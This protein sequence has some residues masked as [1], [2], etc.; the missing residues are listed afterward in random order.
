MPR[1]LSI[2]AAA[3]A[4]ALTG[5]CASDSPDSPDDQAAPAPTAEATQETTGGTTAPLL[6]PAGAEVGTV[7]LAFGSD[8]AT[9]VVQVSDLA[10]GYHGFHVHESGACEPDSPS[11]SDP[12]KVGDFLSAGGHLA[13]GDQ[14]HGEHDGDLPSLLVAAD[15]TASL[16]VTSDRLDEAA[17]LDDDGSALMVH[18]G[19]DNFANVPD[20][21]AP[22]GPDE[23]T[24]DTGDSGGRVACAVLQAG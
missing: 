3:L 14:V 5:A 11:P 10:P 12:A 21:Y 19:P 1:P 2:A 7:E 13:E 9:L 23:M 18:D 8:G 16:T 4:L 6:D 24:E 20:R 17:V 22:Q 15:G